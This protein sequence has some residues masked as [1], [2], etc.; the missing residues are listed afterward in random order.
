MTLLG[1]SL[2]RSML[3]ICLSA[4]RVLTLRCLLMLTGRMVARRLPA[5]S[6]VWT[7]GSLV[8]G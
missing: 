7:D 1:L 3:A 8:M 5:N 6:I 4:L 2:L